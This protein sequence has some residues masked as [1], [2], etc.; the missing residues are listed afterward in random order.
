LTAPA[1]GGSA[2]PV[3]DARTP[4]ARDMQIVAAVLDG[5]EAAFEALVRRYHESMV[6]IATT[7]VRSRAVAEEVAQ[8]TWIAMLHGL[9]RFEGRSPL[10]TW[11]F[12][13]LTK[14]AIT[15]GI[16]E[17]R[18]V[19][20]SALGA[21]D[22]EPVVPAERF[23]EADHPLYPGHWATPPRRW[24]DLPEARL[25][26][27]ETRDQVLAAVDDLPPA[28]RAVIV[29]RDL[30]GLDAA[31]VCELLQL[32]HGNQR[33]LLHRARSRVRAALERY[34]DQEAA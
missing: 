25:L 8:E 11:L 9:D 5:D 17:N 18:T 19:P 16:R 33:V 14:R 34:F 3:A 7:F 24:D 15:R 26:A 10:R 21:D 1:L 20:F 32:T 22:D 31:E 27:R 29:L 30:Q 23:L 28:Q 6:R 13:I 4:A 2:G 12:R